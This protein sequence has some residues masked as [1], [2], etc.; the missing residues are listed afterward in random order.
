MKLARKFLFAVVSI[1]LAVL[2]IGVVASL[3]TEAALQKADIARDH[4][5]VGHAL[6]RLCDRIPEDR[7]ST[8]APDILR[9]ALPGRERI[10]AHLLSRS[11]PARAPVA[12][13]LFERAVST[14]E[15]VIAEEVEGKAAFVTVVPLSVKG[16][17]VELVEPVAEQRRFLHRMALRFVLTAL[18][19]T[20][21]L[22]LSINYVGRRFIGG[23]MKLLVT[24][25]RRIGAGK[26]DETTPLEQDDEIGELAR[27]LNAMALR[28]RE[29]DERARAENEKRLQAVEQLRHA[30]RLATV[31]T[32]A[33]GIA[34]EL[35]TPLA[36]VQGRAALI[37]EAAP[38]PDVI[39]SARVIVEQVHRMTRI[40][41]QVLDFARRSTPKA[42]SVNL[43]D[44]VDKAALLLSSISKKHG[45][46]IR[47]T[48]TS[49]TVVMADPGLM[50]QVFTNLLMNAVQASTGKSEVVLVRVG[51]VDAAPPGDAGGPVRCYG[52]VEIEDHGKGI[53]EDQILHVFEP[54]FTTKGVGEGTGLGLSVAWG[55]V[56][57]HDGWIDVESEVERGSTFRV[58]LPCAER[59]G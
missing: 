21:G 54:F 45:V 51:E 33:S 19:L 32:L 7:L 4:T 46:E 17:A 58:Y 22:V 25:A 28:L 48:R 53:P 34:H 26:L 52:R 56:Q 40:I 30:D 39:K 20:I 15:A 57:D 5:I 1:A 50:H 16:M 42:T 41:R 37:E 6:A 35:G 2:A 49:P 13:A 12:P 23:P 36:V 44:L 59:E 47:V 3:L 24:Q 29:S 43:A 18:V 10:Q 27:E 11:D 55:I 38:D 14:G 8:E 31:G 9:F